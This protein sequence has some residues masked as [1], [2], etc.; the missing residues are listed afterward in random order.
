MKKYRPYFTIPEMEIIS[1]HLKQGSPD[2][3]KLNLIRYF[4]KFLSDA[5]AGLRIPNHTL[6]PSLAQRMELES[7]PPESD[8]RKLYQ[9]WID[10]GENFYVFTGEQIRL[11]QQ[12]RYEND[13][14]TPT[15]ESQFEQEQGAWR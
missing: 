7:P 11:I 14:M 9:S 10:C 13:M 5:K 12:H 2:P 1:S 4:D 8:P 6:M 15:E 3:G